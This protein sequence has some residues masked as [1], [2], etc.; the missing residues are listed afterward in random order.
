[1]NNLAT[2]GILGGGQLGRML[3]LAGYP[4]GLR[5]K[6]LDP[7]AEA[8]AGDV[9]ELVVG[10]YDD[11]AALATFV[12]GL[13]VIT[14]EFENVPLEATST[15]AT[16]CPIYP[17][18][19]ALATAQG[20][21]TEKQF[22]VSLKIPT[23]PFVPVDETADLDHALREL[24]LPM[25]FKLRR[26]GYDGKGQ[27]VVHSADAMY[28]AWQ[29]L[30]GMPLIAERLIA[31][32]RELSL[33]AVR[34]VRGA[35]SYYPLTE[36]LHIQGML[37][38]S[39]APAVA[40]GH[41]LQAEA[42]TYARRVLDALNYVGVLA[43]EFFQVQ[44]HLVINEMAPRVHNSGHW[45]IEGADTSQFENHLRA[46]LGLP[47]GST[48]P[49]G[50]SAMLNLVGSLPDLPAVLAMRGAHL[51]HYTKVPRAGRKIGHVTL[52]TSTL[53]ELHP[54]LAE[55]EQIIPGS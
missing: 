34:S 13:D 20:R 11:P 3:A 22:F 12:A 7:A 54:R 18:P 16:F 48:A 30:R 50:A 46:V 8:C 51:H 1:M 29:D 19:A 6:V 14:Y 5:F 27:V 43:L 21:L 52:C 40:P 15:L 4:L 10:T 26:M 24:G 9:A 49:R 33:I 2:I 25:V 41:P 39:L 55:L 35:V 17:P 36:N 32:E 53:A 38:R 23:V 37:R 47:L 28:Q 42:E 45:T 44:G 31:F